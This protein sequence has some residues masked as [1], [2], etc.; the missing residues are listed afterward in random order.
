MYGMVY[1]PH[2]VTP[3]ITHKD[4]LFLGLLRLMFKALR[5]RRRYKSSRLKTRITEI[6]ANRATIFFQKRRRKFKI[7]FDIARAIRNVHIKFY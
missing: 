2:G 6:C 4:V 1:N 5:R 3:G 7:G